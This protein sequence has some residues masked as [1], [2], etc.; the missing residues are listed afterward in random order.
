MSIQFQKPPENV[1]FDLSRKMNILKCKFD[2]L[3]VELNTTKDQIKDI[4]KEPGSKVTPE[5][6]SKLDLISVE[7]GNPILKYNTGVCFQNNVRSDVDNRMSIEYNPSQSSVY[8]HTLSSHIRIP[9]NFRVILV[10]DE[11]HFIKPE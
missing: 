5:Q 1:L 3:L 11:I 10:N 6:E 4:L 2:D 7:N 8:I 9:N